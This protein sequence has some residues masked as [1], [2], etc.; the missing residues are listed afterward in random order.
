MKTRTF[1]IE[2]TEQQYKQLYKLVA[3][4]FY[5]LTMPQA[6]RRIMS[7]ALSLLLQSEA[8]DRKEIIAGRNNFLWKE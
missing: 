8:D 1:E 2:V 4:G 5:G 6:I 7:A 3:G